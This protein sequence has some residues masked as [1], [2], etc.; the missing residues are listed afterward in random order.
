MGNCSSDEAR[1][2]GQPEPVR[3][4]TKVEKIVRIFRFDEDIISFY[5][6]GRF[7]R[8]KQFFSYFREDDFFESDFLKELPER[9]IINLF[10][11]SV[12][13]NKIHTV[14]G[15]LEFRPDLANITCCGGKTPLG[16]AA[17]Y[18]YGDMVDLLLTK[19]ADVNASGDGMRDALSY[20]ICVTADFDNRDQIR[21]IQ[22]LINAGADTRKRI[23]C[24]NGHETT[25][26]VQAVFGTRKFGSASIVEL[27]LPLSDI[28]AKT[29]YEQTA[30]T[31]AVRSIFTV[32]TAGTVALLLDHGADVTIY[33]AN[34][35]YPYQYAE[36]IKGFPSQLLERLRLPPSY[37]QS[38]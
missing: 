2:R 7:L 36:A 32:S 8:I 19:G 22:A 10:W 29:E 38:T 18:C 9:T 16:F 26:L 35:K 33:E 5:G 27:L 1:G 28:N 6:L 37:E 25:H 15:L 24:K 20:A 30:L 23:R 31:I 4:E 21:I 17:Y 11:A 12:V 13:F 14:S 3:E 34:G